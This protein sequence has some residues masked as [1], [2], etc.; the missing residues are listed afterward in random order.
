MHFILRV[1]RGLAYYPALSLFGLMILHILF[2]QFSPFVIWVKILLFLLINGLLWHFRKVTNYTGLYALIILI[3]CSLYMQQTIPKS[4]PPKDDIYTFRIEVTS[5]SNKTMWGQVRYNVRIIELSKFDSNLIQKVYGEF[6]FYSRKSFHVGSLLS[7]T[8]LLES[9]PQKEKGVRVKKERLLG[10]LKLLKVEEVEAPS[11]FRVKLNSFNDNLN[12]IFDHILLTNIQD[13]SNGILLQSLIKG[14]KK[15]F[16]KESRFSVFEKSGQ[17]HFFAVSG[18]HIGILFFIIFYFL[19]LIRLQFKSALIATIGL[20]LFYIYFIDFP[21]S[22]IRAWLMLSLWAL[23]RILKKPIQSLNLF[24]TAGII[25]LT[26]TPMQL[27]HM[28]FQFSFYI[29]LLL[30]LAWPAVQRSR[31]VIFE[32][33]HWTPNQIRTNKKRYILL[34]KVYS[35]FMVSTIAFV[36]SQL[37]LGVYQSYL[38]PASI[39]TTLINS[40]IIWLLLFLISIKFILFPLELIGI[41]LIPFVINKVCNL[42]VTQTSLLLEIFPIIPTHIHAIGTNSLFLVILIIVL[43]TKYPIFR[44]SLLFTVWFLL[45][46]ITYQ[47]N[48]KNILLFD[49]KSENLLI[50]QESRYGRKLVYYEKNAKREIPFYLLKG[51]QI[52]SPPQLI[53]T[54][55]EYLRQFKD[56]Y[57]LATIEAFKNHEIKAY[58]LRDVIIK[59]KQKDYIFNKALIEFSDQKKTYS[60]SRSPKTL[61]GWYLYEF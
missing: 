56:Q 12:K 22:A 5:K 24:A 47:A 59:S 60:T 4:Q 1:Q 35:L 49:A 17:L 7:A 46:Q 31:K 2:L 42:L 16:K 36:A 14:D 39:P 28:G 9:F 58:K 18:L 26:F 27:F 21:A 13:H 55:S 20:L 44:M 38:T 57:P 54:N 41:K 40:F 30:I 23:S 50:I 10:Q 32:K 34:S 48:T 11:Y 52:M 15:E 25:I 51:S 19:K 45:G 61:K 37:L 8:G 29:V 6:Y 53:T 33:F 3:S 43:K